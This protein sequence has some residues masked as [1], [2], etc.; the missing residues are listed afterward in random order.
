MICDHLD[1]DDTA[2]ILTAGQARSLRFVCEST[3]ITKN[4]FPVGRGLCP[5]LEQV[6]LMLY[7]LFCQGIRAL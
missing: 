4:I 5:T 1:D 7:E 6:S 3:F 2:R